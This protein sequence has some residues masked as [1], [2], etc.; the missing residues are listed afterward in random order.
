M[1]WE[2][3]RKR[4]L[5]NRSNETGRRFSILSHNVLCV[6]FVNTRLQILKNYDFKL[7]LSQ[8]LNSAFLIT[9]LF[10]LILWYFRENVVLVN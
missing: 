5:F 10:C 9:S 8:S 4:K 3:S 2:I 1:I 7:R 6:Q